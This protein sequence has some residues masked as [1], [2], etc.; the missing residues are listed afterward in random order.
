[1]TTKVKKLESLITT[2]KKILEFYSKNP[3]I[4]FDSMNCLLIDLLDNL[5]TDLTGSMTNSITHDILNNVKEICIYN[6]KLFLEY[7]KNSWKSPI[8]NKEL[9]LILKFLLDYPK[10]II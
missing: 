8:E 3:H 7:G 5:K 2:N 9:Q 10:S 1:M 6:Q 4:D